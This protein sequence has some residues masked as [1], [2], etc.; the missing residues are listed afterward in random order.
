V[1][2]EWL[3]NLFITDG[4]RV[5]KLAV[6]SEVDDSGNLRGALSD[7]QAGGYQVA[8]FFLGFLSCAYTERPQEL[9]ER[10]F[11]AS[12]AWLNTVP[13]PQ[14]RTNLELALLAQLRSPRTELDPRT[15]AQENLP[16]EDQD[17]FIDALRES[18]VPIRPFGKDLELV[19]PR[20]KRVQI[21][22]VAGV[23]VI[24]PPECMTDGTI[25]VE[26]GS[27]GQASVTIRDRV[28]RIGSR[29]GM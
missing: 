21:D 18:G 10:F 6:F 7:E 17:H 13:D 15:F 1:D 29:G 8:G 27:Q 19:A 5:F 22:T 24:A 12:Q 9:T 4:T 26:T 11:D 2:I 14:R 16:P 20:M 28:R 3:R 23:V 25:E